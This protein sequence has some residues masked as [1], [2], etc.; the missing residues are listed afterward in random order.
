MLQL[1]LQQVVTGK[2]L[3]KRLESREFSEL[4]LKKKII[5][6]IFDTIKMDCCNLILV[7]ILLSRK[8]AFCTLRSFLLRQ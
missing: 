3:R 1:R 2:A 6:E 7:M 5:I 4:A 8:M